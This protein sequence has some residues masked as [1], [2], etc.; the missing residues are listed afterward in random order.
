MAV[1]DYYNIAQKFYVAYFGRPAD[2]SGL[3]NIA[4][5]LAAA[6]APTTTQAFVDAYRSNATVRSIIDSFGD[7]SESHELYTGDTRAFVTAIFQNVLGRAPNA[8]GL[9]YWAQ[10]I[11]QGELSRGTAALTIMAGAESNTSSQGKVDAATVAAKIV[12]AS[13]FTSALGTPVAL[14]SYS[15][16]AAA[17]AARAMLGELSSVTAT[18]ERLID[19]VPG[20][21]DLLAA[22]DSGS[23]STDNITRATSGL[24]ITGLAPGAARVELFDGATKVGSGT[25]TNGSFSVDIAL[26]AALHAI[27]AVGYTTAGV[28]SRSSAALSITVDTG[29]PGGE[30]LA[31]LVE[32][33]GASGDAMTNNAS[34]SVAGVDAGNDL[35]YSKD[36]ASW[37]STYTPAAG[38]NI[39]MVRQ[40]DT[41]GNGGPVSVFKFTYDKTAPQLSTSVPSNNVK[42]VGHSS[43]IVL[44]MS[45][46]VVAGS[47]D[48]IVSDGGQDRRVISMSDS[49][50]VQVIG[51]TITIN[52]SL[53]LNPETRYFVTVPAGAATDVAGNGMVAANL[54]FTT[55][56]ATV[57]LL[58]SSTPSASRT[59][60]SPLS[61]LYLDFS[62]SVKAGAG[63]VTISDGAGDRRVISINDSTQVSIRGS[64]VTVNPTLSLK[65]SA[66]YTVQVDAGALKDLSGNAFGGLSQGALGFSTAS[67]TVSLSKL[68][69]N[70][71]YRM[72]VVT[73]SYNPA[74]TSYRI[75]YVTNTGK[76]VAGVG[77][78]NSDGLDD[79]MVVAGQAI[80]YYDTVLD[81][82][83][84]MFVVY[85]NTGNPTSLNLSKLDGQ[86]GMRV[87]FPKGL[88][89]TYMARVAAAGDVNGDGLG[90]LV[91]GDHYYGDSSVPST[92]LMGAAYIVHGANNGRSAFNTSALNG[93][94]GYSVSTGTRFHYLGFSTSGGDINGDGYSDVVVGAPGSGQVSNP[95]SSYILFGSS[96]SAGAALSVSSVDGKNGV[97]ID[98]ETGTYNSGVAMIAGD[99]NGD[100]YADIGIGAEYLNSKGAAYVV[101][102]KPGTWSPTM[103]LSKLT[104]STGLRIT[105]SRYGN[106]YG[107]NLGDQVSSAGDV[108]GDGYADLLIKAS[109]DT[110]YKD[111]V[112]Y[113]VFGRANESSGKLDLATLDGKNGFRITG[114]TSGAITNQGAAAA[115][116]DING[117]GYDDLLI[118]SPGSSL[119]GANAG[120]VYVVFGKGSGFAAAVNVT[121]L[122]A[123][124]TWRIDGATGEYAGTSV[125]AAGDVN[126]DGFADIVIGAPGPGQ[127]TNPNQYSTEGTAYIVYGRDVTG[128][129]RYL[130]DSAA[131]TLTGTS[132]AEN[133]VGGN[134]DDTL[135]G[136]GGADSFHGGAGNDIIVVPDLAARKIDGGSGSDTLR[137]SGAGQT[138]DL[139]LFRNRIEGIETIDL[140][141]SGNNT[142]KVLARDLL[143]LNELSNTLTVDGNAGDKVVLG[144][145]WTD[146][147]VA[148]GYHQYL[149][150]QAVILV[151]IDLTVTL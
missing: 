54:N 30:V 58:L 70:T 107:W 92:T 26:S 51:K 34:L 32:D 9:N 53:P 49:S 29:A 114:N 96:A 64:T 90:D 97:R 102:G 82:T 59:D 100:G 79:V 36:G 14:A 147:G 67:A 118:N 104:A 18:L 22:D 3:A 80:G 127:F 84:S 142:L 46:T 122:D 55:V 43:D 62:E 17:S 94:N 8:E 123:A 12:L 44:T 133:F 87:E 69:T 71:G 25:V 7:S 73:E 95:G 40:T 139:A 111:S 135:A 128:S 19:P 20:A 27:T 89:S 72:T 149:Q 83:Q 74:S 4:A 35:Q 85:G 76:F 78:I 52:P 112:S 116:G 146:G 48:I 131:N 151:G 106:E 141:G 11:D 138:L 108:N 60:V 68:D 81:Y 98:G 134:G 16:K 13:Q 57:P 38:A 28:K 93:A 124:G 101:F 140:S 33:S 88:G 41:A 61:N 109:N 144:A 77:D 10:S 148:G 15:G 56:D 1:A 105:D 50:Q 75:P 65:T 103:A 110:Y 119:G 5:S 115:V 125:S 39:V 37:T 21:L 24:T 136:G 137:L 121:T 91:I 113:V 143:N 150:G 31:S 2:P 23:S 47:G 6:N 45:E 66:S 130:G 132:A 86:N 63:S 99:F 145:G 42:E 117:D 129:V 126:G 120:S